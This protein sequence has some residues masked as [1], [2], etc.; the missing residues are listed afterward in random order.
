MNNTHVYINKLSILH[1]KSLIHHVSI[2]S[3]FNGGAGF[4]LSSS[5]TSIISCFLQFLF[6][7]EQYASLGNKDANVMLC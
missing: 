6:S 5:Y 7:F 2:V 3:M 1:I 4:Q